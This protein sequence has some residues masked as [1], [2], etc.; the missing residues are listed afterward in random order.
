VLLFEFLELSEALFEGVNL[1]QEF[2]VFGRIS[3]GRPASRVVRI[4]ASSAPRRIAGYSAG[5]EGVPETLESS[6]QR[7]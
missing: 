3:H 2:I 7:V 1:F 4:G 6:S 5:G